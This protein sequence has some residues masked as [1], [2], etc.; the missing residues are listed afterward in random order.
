[1]T[2]F[3]MIGLTVQLM[4]SYLSQNLKKALKISGNLFDIFKGSISI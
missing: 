2:P 4:F 1:M 3:A